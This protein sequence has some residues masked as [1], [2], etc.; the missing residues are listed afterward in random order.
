MTRINDPNVDFTT[1]NKSNIDTGE[2]R[3][4]GKITKKVHSYEENTEITHTYDRNVG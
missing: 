1:K 4:G 2:G 3:G